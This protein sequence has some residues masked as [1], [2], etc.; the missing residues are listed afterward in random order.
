VASFIALCNFAWLF[1]SPASAIWGMDESL[2]PQVASGNP[3]WM[4]F[5]FETLLFSALSI[6]LE[7]LSLIK[8]R[9]CIQ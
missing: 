5:S 3:K 2:Q 6:L 8:K 9:G 7:S 1:G 4:L